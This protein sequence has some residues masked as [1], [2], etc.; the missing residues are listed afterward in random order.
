[1]KLI[2]CIQSKFSDINP[3]INMDLIAGMIKSG[4]IDISFVLTNGFTLH[5]TF[6]TEAQRNF[7][8]DSVAMSCGLITYGC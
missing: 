8:Y 6:E 2:G 5:W 1:M 3:L 4:K 7:A